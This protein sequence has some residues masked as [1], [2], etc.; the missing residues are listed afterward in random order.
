M[1]MHRQDVRPDLES[2]TEQT[3]TWRSP[4]DPPFRLAG[5]AWFG[6]DRLYRRL[7][8]E[9]RW[10]LPEVVHALANCTA[11]GQIQFRTDSPAL[12]IRVRLTAPAGMVH[13]PATGQCG[14]D[15]YIGPP[16]RQRYC[17]TTKYDLRR[18]DY[19]CALFDLPEAEMRNV[20]LNFPLYQGVEEVLVGLRPDARVQPPPPYDDPRPVV[21]YGTSIAQGGCASRPGMA[22]TNILSR[23][24]NRPFVNLGFS[25]S[26]RGEPEVARTI[27]EI[28]DPASFVLDYEANAWADGQ[29]EKTLRGFIEIVRE[30]HPVIPILVV[31]KT[32][33]ASE[34][35]DDGALQGRLARRDFQRRTVEELR[36][37]GDKSISFLDGSDLLGQDFDECTV[38]GAHPNDLGFWLMAGGIEPALAD[39]LRS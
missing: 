19:E 13:M 37:A 27:A 35:F 12:A 22:Y 34:S 36:A 4:A 38:D 29:L 32:R 23:R 21:V 11:G 25:G 1:A 26:G 7:P 28:A 20:T 16:K 10:P 18:S 15:C 6:Q 17:S 8:A 2:A 31:S 33:Y 9:A 5:F 24:F 14:F 3:L 30:S 39:I